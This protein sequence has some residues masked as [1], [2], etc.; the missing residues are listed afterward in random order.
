V[1]GEAAG[2]AARVGDVGILDLSLRRWAAVLD[3]DAAMLE[4]VAADALAHGAV[5]ERLLCCDALATLRDTSG[6]PD[7]ASQWRSERDHL[8]DSLAITTFARS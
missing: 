4:E 6:R 1:L 7:E 3:G 2:L 8:A 5:L